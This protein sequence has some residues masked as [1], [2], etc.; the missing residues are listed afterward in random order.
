MESVIM[1]DNDRRSLC[2]KKETSWLRSLVFCPLVDSLL[3]YV[4]FIH[5]SIFDLLLSCHFTP[6]WKITFATNWE[7]DSLHRDLRKSDCRD[8][9][10]QAGRNDHY[11]VTSINP[12]M[13]SLTAA[14]RCGASHQGDRGHLRI[15]FQKL[16]IYCLIELIDCW[17]H[18]KVVTTRVTQT[19]LLLTLML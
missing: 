13:H 15:N 17:L 12:C 10:M 11:Q 3:F 9:Y 6:N 7:S 2:F 1:R 16:K 14:A 18:V 19:A 5:W 8:F 4:S